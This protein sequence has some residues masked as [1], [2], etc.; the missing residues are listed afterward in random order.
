[1]TALALV[2][3]GAGVVLVYSGITGQNPVT[4]AQAVLGGSS[5]TPRFPRSPGGGDFGPGDPR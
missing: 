5:S 1:M 2:L 3:I 4:E